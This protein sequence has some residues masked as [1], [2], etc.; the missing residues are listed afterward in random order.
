MN[1]SFFNQS[2]IGV[3][4]RHDISPFNVNGKKAKCI[5]NYLYGK[6]KGGGGG[7]FFLMLCK[8][9][10]A[11]LVNIGFSFVNKLLPKLNKG[12]ICLLQFGQK[13][14]FTNIIRAIKILIKCMSL[15]EI[16]EKYK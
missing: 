14:Y 15:H 6:G 11:P 7:Y 13:P 8:S 9:M 4:A 2:Y 1:P 3:S 10:P 5:T 16:I 12:Q